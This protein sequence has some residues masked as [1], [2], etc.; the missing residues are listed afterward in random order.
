MDES[1]PEHTEIKQENEKSDYYDPL[2]PSDSGPIS[3]N[4]PPESPKNERER[5]QNKNER[6]PE[7]RK[8]ENRDENRGQVS[9]PPAKKQKLIVDRENSCPFLLRVFVRVNSDWR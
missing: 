3:K 6:K 2:E 1:N 7:E 5:V 8:Q 9:E 4:E